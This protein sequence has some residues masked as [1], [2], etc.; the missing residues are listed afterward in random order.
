MKDDSQKPARAISRRQFLRLSAVAGATMGLAACGGEPP[1]V[2]Q[3]TAA[4]A[5]AEPTAAPAAEPTAAPVIPTAPAVAPTSAPVAADTKFAEAPMLADM[6]SSGKIPAV[7]Q[8]LP[9]NPVVLDG[10]DGVGK[11]GGSLRRG[12]KGVS[13][14]W[15][16]TKIQNES[17][18]WYN[19]D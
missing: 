7:D 6:V 1:A 12:F 15:G 18:T 2:I 16:P 19:S 4:P 3:P 10:L 13:D 8:R 5:A 17:L 11:F 9:K 14:R